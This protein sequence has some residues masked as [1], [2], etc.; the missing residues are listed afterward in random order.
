MLASFAFIYKFVL[1]SLPLLSIHEQLAI[2]QLPSRTVRLHPVDE[3]WPQLP[4]QKMTISPDG[5]HASPAPQELD[6]VATHPTA[7]AEKVFSRLNVSR[8]HAAAAGALAGLSI[9]WEKKSRRMMI[10]QQ[11][12]VRYGFASVCRQSS[13]P[14]FPSGLQG[15]W[16]AWNPRW[17]VHVPYGSTIIFGLWFVPQILK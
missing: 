7:A 6:G 5:Y 15:T 2:L 8:W 13:H 16:N 17:G 9:L 4:S 12:F 11:L 10:S 3:E 14:V 1:N